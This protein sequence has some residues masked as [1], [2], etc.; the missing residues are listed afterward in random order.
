MASYTSSLII[1]LIDQATGP[2]RAIAKALEGVRAA[3]QRNAQALAAARAGM[4]DA[5]AMGFTLYHAL[6]SP[7]EAAVEFESKLLDIGQKVDVPVAK[8]GELG[9]QIKAVAK[10]TNQSTAQM[11]EGM[12]VLAG[13]GANRSDALEMLK[14]IGRAAFAYKASIA[15]LSQAGY[16]ALSN[17]KVPAKEFGAALDAMSEAGK[18]G[19]FELKDM[20]QYFPELGAG[21]QAL[22]QTGVSAVADLASALQVVRTGTGDSASAATNLSNIL[23]KMNAPLTQ[24]NFQKMGVNLEK[25]LKKASKLGMSPIE[26]ITEITNRTLKGDMSKLGYL[27]NDAQVQQGMRPL[28][29]NLQM[30]RDIRKQAMAAQ[31]SVEKDYQERLQ[32]GQAAIARFSNAIENLKLA[33][34]SSLLPV[35]ST[36]AETIVP[37]I[38]AFG[39][40]AAANPG[41]TR[42]IVLT[43]SALIALRVATLAGRYSWLLFQG[44]LLSA[45]GG[46]LNFARL[47]GAGLLAPLRLSFMALRHPILLVI[48]SLGLLRIALISTVVGAA[49]VALGAAA[50]WIYNNWDGVSTAFI[51]FKDALFEALKP[52]MPLLQPV[53]NGIKWVAAGLSNLLGPI[54]AGKNKWSEFGQIAG[55][56]VGNFAVSLIQL[57]GKIWGILK[58]I[59]SFLAQLPGRFLQAGIRAAK[60]LGNGVR[61]GIVWVATFLG[62][63]PG[64]LREIIVSKAGEF[65]EAGKVLMYQLW[66]GIKSVMGQIV[67]YIKTAISDAAHAAMGKIKGLFSFGKGTEDSGGTTDAE[68]EG[69]RASGGPVNAGST[70]LVG[71]RGRELFT[72]SRSG[73]IVKASE[74]AQYLRNN[75]AA[76]RLSLP[77]VPRVGSP[78]SG[79]AHPGARAVTVN[80]GGITVNVPGAQNMDVNSLAAKVAEMVGQSV[81][82]SAAGAFSD[83]VY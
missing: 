76:R 78:I 42:A 40:F 81:Q 63:V 75:F 68:V 70:Y 65:L 55:K 61:D 53:I 54:S 9:E 6:K 71:E 82:K 43:T 22:G 79:G 31:G 49:L 1:K 47:A 74:T 83:G 48:R 37:L 15:D 30:Y 28:L 52:V 14:P 10:Y 17:L 66:E 64:R 7:T 41:L 20:A 19:A 18:A 69:A 8:L 59:G 26:A 2:S 34:G 32:T 36:A 57:P 77:Q 35:L 33:I 60:A 39:D 23:Q 21:Y 16:S 45:K 72:P 24:K 46:L 13:M 51:A 44:G 29:Q 4:L 80:V 38:N 67:E 5:A 27:F 62:S 58:T 3:Q 25:E 50:V 73:F 12:D 11:A 56:A